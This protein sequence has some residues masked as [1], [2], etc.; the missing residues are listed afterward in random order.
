VSTNHIIAL[1]FF[2][3]NVFNQARTRPKTSTCPNH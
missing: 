1:F 3:S 2:S